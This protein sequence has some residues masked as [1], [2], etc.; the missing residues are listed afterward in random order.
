VAWNLPV[1]RIKRTLR[2]RERDVQAFIE[3]HTHV[4]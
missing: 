1:V 2:F 4:A 3:H